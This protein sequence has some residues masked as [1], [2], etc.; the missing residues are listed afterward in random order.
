MTTTPSTAA[1]ANSARLLS[2]DAYRGFIMICL[3]WGGF[4]LAKFCDLKMQAHPESGWWRF[5]H[6][7][8]DH[9]PWAGWG[10]WDLIM[11]AFIFMVGMAMPFSQARRERE[12]HT[13]GRIVRH[14][15]IRSGVLILLGIFLASHSRPKD[16]WTLTNTLAQIGLCYPLAA[17]VVGRGFR[18]Q[19]I[20]ASGS[21]VVTWLLFVLHGGSSQLGPGVTPEWAAAHHAGMSQA[22]WK[23]SNV[24]HAFD[25][26]FLGL[27]PQN[28]PFV[29]NEGG[30]QT[31]NFLPSLFTMIGGIACADWVRAKDADASRK[32]R[33]MLIAGA[34]LVLVGEIIG[35]SGLCPLVKRIWTPSF[36]LVC[37]GMCVLMLAAFHYIVDMR[38]W[39]RWTFPLMVAGANS[40]ALYMMSQ[41]LKPWVGGLWQRYLGKD[42]F[43]IAGPEP[44][45]V[46]RCSAIGFTFWLVVYWMYRNKFFVR[47]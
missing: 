4:G 22:W 40:L 32:L 20:V 13:R 36:G 33:V 28:A 30:Y 11:P 25:V 38:G 42:V 41:L 23:C 24:A 31:L 44:E 37:T 12:G 18:V 16:A 6:A 21:L 39:K 9:G 8:L 7:Q 29:A 2:L 45:S 15:L 14:T 10:F 35:H 47:I 1:E 5:L 34:A 3:S 17:L 19:A 26:W 46:L 27:F 43:L